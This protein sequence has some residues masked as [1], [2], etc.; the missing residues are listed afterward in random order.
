VLDGIVLLTLTERRQFY[1]RMV[2]AAE[3]ICAITFVLH[4]PIL[5]GGA[6]SNY[7]AR[8]ALR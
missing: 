5:A 6:L 4:T 8:C 2:W 3:K 1:S 7:N